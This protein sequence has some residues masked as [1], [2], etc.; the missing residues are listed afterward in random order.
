[1]VVTQQE[2]T[3]ERDPA[4]GVDY[5]ALAGWKRWMSVAGA[6][7][8]SFG[9]VAL[10]LDWLGIPFNATMDTVRGIEI[11]R[12]LNAA[13]FDRHLRGWPQPVLDHPSAGYPEVTR[14]TAPA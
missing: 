14:Y 5:A 3:A 4:L 10:M 6:A 11:S 9:D 2:H 13:M 1:M 7:H 8:E 12:R